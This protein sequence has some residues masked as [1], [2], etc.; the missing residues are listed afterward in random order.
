MAH[1]RE[2][3]LEVARAWLTEGTRVAV[4]TVVA[5]WRSSPRPV[6]SQMVIAADGRFAGSVSGGCVEGA[7][8]AAAQELLGAGPAQ[9]AFRR[10]EFGV[11]TEQAW[12]VGLPCGGTIE[13]SLAEAAA[14]LVER[15]CAARARRAT[16]ALLT[17]LESGQAELWDPS[18][19]SSLLDGDAR[20]AAAEVVHRERSAVLE[21]SGRRLFVHVFGAPLRLVAVGAVHLT[22]AL[23]ELAQ[24]A[25]IDVTVVDPRTAFATVERFPG[26][27]LVHEWPDE[28]L[29][30]LGLDPR[31]AVVVLSHDAKLDEPALEVALRSDCFYVGALGSQRTQRARRERLSDAGFD[32]RAIGRIHGPIGLDIGALTTPEIAI[33]I[34]AEMIQAFRRRGVDAA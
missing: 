24:L 2:S 32:E 12:D 5:T 14:P 16:S 18:A 25:G 34:M 19:G 17:C 22:Q 11:S 9:G 20:R 28:A 33:S 4:A 27:A 31:T 8:I 23:A 30:R 13:V 10:L 1:D 26:V 7:V 15:L 29:A 21:L 3:V 6:G